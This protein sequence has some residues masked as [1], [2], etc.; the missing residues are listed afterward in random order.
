MKKT[1]LIALS[2]LSTTIAFAA[3]PPKEIELTE[4]EQQLIVG[5]NDFAFNLFRKARGDKSCIM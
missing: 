5:N 2:I 1:I 4:D 3:A